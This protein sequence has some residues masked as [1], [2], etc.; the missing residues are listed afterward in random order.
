MVASLA[1]TSARKSRR[2]RAQLSLWRSEQR[3]QETWR[4]HGRWPLL[5]ALKFPSFCET[6]R[7]EARTNTLIR[8]GTSSLPHLSDA[9]SRMQFAGDELPTS[10]R[11][12]ETF[13][14]R[15][16]LVSKTPWRRTVAEEVG[17]EPTEGFPSHDFQ[18]CRFGRSRTPPM[19]YS[20]RVEHRLVRLPEARRFSDNLKAPKLKAV[21]GSRATVFREPSQGWKPAAL[22][23][24]RRVPR[25]AWPPLWTPASYHPP[26]A[27]T[28]V[29]HQGDPLAP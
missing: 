26:L 21:V 12:G 27:S 1:L 2:Q 22:S 4:I 29:H 7:P 10:C 14:N 9:S 25:I 11:R 20:V 13:V 15:W 17:F 24:L 18:S 5:R 16:G 23:E 28:H 19:R 3:V 8:R 6:L